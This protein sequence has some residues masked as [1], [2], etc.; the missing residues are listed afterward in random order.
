VKRTH[1]AD[2]LIQEATCLPLPLSTAYGQFLLRTFTRHD[3]DEIIV[4]LVKGD[5]SS[6]QGVLTRLHSECLT[7]D[8][9]ASLRCD[10]GI[11]LKYALR[12]IASEERGVLLYIIGHEGR[13][14]GLL[15]KLKAYQIQDSGLD[16]AEANEALGLPIDSRDYHAAASVLQLL[17]ISSVRLLTNNPAKIAALAEGGINIE[18]RVPVHAAPHARNMRYLAT[19]RDKFGHGAPKSSIFDSKVDDLG[20]IDELL[21]EVKTYRDRPYVV[22]KYAQTV[23]GRIATSSGD[24]KW[25]S[26]EP[27]RRLTHALRAYC[28]AVI[29]GVGTVVAD[30]PL[31]TVRHVPGSSPTRVILDSRLRIPW[32]AQVLNDDAPTVVLTTHASSAETRHA[33]LRR[34]VAVR[35]VRGAAGGVDLKDGLSALA[36]M[37]V[38][39]LLVEGGVG[40]ITSFLRS[41]LVDRAVIAIAPMIIG[42]GREAIGDLGIGRVRDALRLE[43]SMVARVGPDIL[44]VG[45]IGHGTAA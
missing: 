39:T 21:G 32:E 25:I 8:V 13:G 27:E 31:L 34:S 22:L 16:T 18:E 9:F 43:N 6:G 12:A 26:G 44:M 35:C 33:L 2:S 7:G 20:G 10:C 11:Q 41:N 19:K 1:S 37:G 3:S 40:V 15:N 23:D 38:S 24:S 36:E 17:G 30:D 14:I 29:V 45:D 4:G 5:I 28:D 42:E